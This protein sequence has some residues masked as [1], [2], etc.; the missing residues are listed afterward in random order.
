MRVITPSGLAAIIIV[1]SVYT[2]YVYQDEVDI[3]DEKAGRY[4]RRRDN[5]GIKNTCGHKRFVAE[6]DGALASESNTDPRAHSKIIIGGVA[7][8]R[9]DN[10]VFASMERGAYANRLLIFERAGTC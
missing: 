4:Q 10:S 1:T 6:R 9:L 8:A 5:Q 3:T 7:D 2:A